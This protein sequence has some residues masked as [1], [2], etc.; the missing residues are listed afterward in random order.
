MDKEYCEQRWDMEPRRVQQLVAAAEAVQAIQNANNCSYFPS[1]DDLAHRHRADRHRRQGLG[2]KGGPKSVSRFYRHRADRHPITYTPRTHCHVDQL[3]EHWRFL[4]FVWR[5][6][7]LHIGFVTGALAA[8]W[9][10]IPVFDG[11][12]KPG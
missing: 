2:S 8:D 4:L 3:C 9:R 6:F 7:P 10:L 11:H 1:R 12:P 5:I